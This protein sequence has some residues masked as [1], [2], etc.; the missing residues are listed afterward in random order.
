MRLLVTDTATQS[1]R[2]ATA[3]LIMTLGKMKKLP[4]DFTL[5]RLFNTLEQVKDNDRACILV[6]CGYI[7]LLSNV[8]V[9]KHCKNSK[10]IAKDIRSYPFAARLL[11]LN[12]LGLITDDVYAAVDHFRRLRNDAAHNA[13]FE[14]DAKLYAGKFEFH[15]YTPTNMHD[16]CAAL[17]FVFWSR[18]KESFGYEFKEINP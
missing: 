7:E 6:A 9:L 16:L 15:V 4:K 10:N 13:F 2:Q 5:T 1:P 14:V 11:I 18:H 8:L 12:E 17:C 3:W